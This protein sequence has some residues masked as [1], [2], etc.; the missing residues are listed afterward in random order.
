[1]LLLL[2]V[3]EDDVSVAAGIVVVPVGVE[4]VKVEPVRDDE[5]ERIVVTVD[6]IVM[7]PEIEVIPPAMLAAVTPSSPAGAIANTLL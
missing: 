6:V 5:A 7:D 1:M 3:V 4:V 2:V